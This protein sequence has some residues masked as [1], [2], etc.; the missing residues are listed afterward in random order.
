[1]VWLHRFGWPWCFRPTNLPA[2]SFL[3]GIF[4]TQNRAG[5][6]VGHLCT[7]GIGK[8]SD[9]AVWGCGGRFSRRRTKV[10]KFFI[11]QAHNFHCIA[12]LWK[13][14]SMKKVTVV[15]S[16]AVSQPKNCLIV[17]YHISCLRK[18]HHA[19]PTLF[20]CQVYL[21]GNVFVTLFKPNRPPPPGKR[22]FAAIRM[23]SLM[24]YHKWCGKTITSTFRY[25]CAVWMQATS[26]SLVVGKK[27]LHICLK[28]SSILEVSSRL[29]A[30]LNFAAYAWAWC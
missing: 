30:N 26:G 12:T 28:P 20:S 16:V 25:L 29:F 11:M 15:R 24:I 8:Q 18:G 2:G 9:R 23:E 7:G 27:S 13:V 22:F 17:I 1:M 10:G 3:G 6:L 5:R 19:K 14:F 21:W 4:T